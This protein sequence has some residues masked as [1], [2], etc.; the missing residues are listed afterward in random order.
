M[1]PLPPG[2]RLVVDASE[3]TVKE[4][5]T[6]PAELIKLHK[7][8]VVIH[9]VQNLHAK[10]YVTGREAFVGSA[11]VSGRSADALVEALLHTTERNAV[12]EARAFVNGLCLYPL[13]MEQLQELDG[14]YEPPSIQAG[15]RPNGLAGKTKKVVP[16]M[17]ELRVARI[18]TMVAWPDEEE[19]MR[20]KAARAAARARQFEDATHRLDEFRWAG[21]CLFAKGQLVIRV[22]RDGDRVWVYPAGY[23]LHVE[24]HPVKNVSYV[25]IEYPNRRRKSFE[26]VEAQLNIGAAK[27]LARSGRVSNLEHLRSLLKLSNR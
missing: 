21:T 11:N 13:G 26:R 6:C 8:G 17:P 1:L 3:G 12:A 23:V 9:S 16:E 14:L 22:L 4:G 25:E 2:S 20:T 18:S 10:I 5:M 24:K 19:G 15:G 27:A 7:A